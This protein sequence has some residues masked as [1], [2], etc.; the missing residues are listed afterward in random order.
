MVYGISNKN[1]WCIIPSKMIRSLFAAATFNDQSMNILAS[2]PWI[3]RKHRELVEREKK[4]NG[5]E[6]GLTHLIVIEFL[7]K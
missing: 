5:L 7:S 6:L 2:T 3:L 4:G 1:N